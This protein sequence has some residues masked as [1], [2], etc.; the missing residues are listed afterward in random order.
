MAEMEGDGDRV[1]FMPPQ[2]PKVHIVPQPLSNLLLY[3]IGESKQPEEVGKVSYYPK[4]YPI[5]REAEREKLVLRVI[6]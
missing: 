5:S 4:V 2:A 3:L 1:A 6:Q